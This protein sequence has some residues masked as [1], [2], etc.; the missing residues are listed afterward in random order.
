MKAQLNK[1]IDTLEFL[2]QYV[3]HINPRDMTAIT[4]AVVTAQD[5]L[6]VRVDWPEIRGNPYL[7]A[8]S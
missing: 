5:N 6:A 8:T 4:K 3:D 7:Q 2:A 1:A